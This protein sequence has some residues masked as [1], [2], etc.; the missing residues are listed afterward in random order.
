MFC[1]WRRLCV[2]LRSNGRSGSLRLLVPTDPS[3][4][5]P[6]IWLLGCLTP[7][8]MVDV[9]TSLLHRLR[10]ILAWIGHQAQFR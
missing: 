2:Q 5:V 10:R 1:E 8:G 6:R 3:V 9:P 7:L 4:P